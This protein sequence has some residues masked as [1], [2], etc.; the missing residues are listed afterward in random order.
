VNFREHRSPTN[1]LM[2]PRSSPPPDVSALRSSRNGLTEP[3]QK[4]RRG[5]DTNCWRR[6]LEL[7]A[8]RRSAA[9]LF[10]LTNE[11]KLV[12]THRKILPLHYTTAPRRFLLYS[13]GVHNR[14]RSAFPAT[15]AHA[16]SWP[17]LARERFHA[18]RGEN[19][20]GPH[21]ERSTALALHQVFE[22]YA[23]N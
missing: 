7:E 5:S 11:H 12:D 4:I 3:L 20:A 14:M 22:T 23:T 8:R 2:Q 17:P 6:P 19:A 16:A 1:C 18:W 10:S 15:P 21:R 13:F 9:A